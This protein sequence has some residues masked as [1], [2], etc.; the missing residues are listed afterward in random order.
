MRGAKGARG[1]YPM[2]PLGGGT[3]GFGIKAFDT[4]PAIGG[5]IQDTLTK[6]RAAKTIQEKVTVVR[7]QA[8]TRIQ[9]ITSGGWRPTGTSAQVGPGFP[10]PPFSGRRSTIPGMTRPILQIPSIRTAGPAP[11]VKT[12]SSIKT[13]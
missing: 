1:D 5:Q 10:V 6:L 7:S 13:Y 3:S 12:G 11:M 2:F 4:T 8:Q 9:K